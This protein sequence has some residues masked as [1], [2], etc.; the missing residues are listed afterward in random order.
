MSWLAGQP[1]CK[2]VVVTSS[3]SLLSQWRPWLWR[4]W[5]GVVLCAGVA[6][7]ATVFNNHVPLVSAMLVAIVAGVVARN[8]RG[9][10]V[11]ADPGLALTGRTVLRL[12]VVLLGLRLSLRAVAS[13]GW[14]ALGVIALTVLTVFAVTVWVGPRLGVP[15]AAVVLTATGTAICGAAAVA[16]MSAVV[17][18]D[19]V[20]R[21]GGSQAADGAVPAVSGGDADS[22]EESVDE[23]ATTAIASVTLFGTVALLVLPLLVRW[24]GL[25]ATPAGVWVG[26]SVHEVGQVVAAG[27]LISPEV[28]DVAVVAKLGRVVLLA[29]LIAVVGALEGRRQ[30]RLAGLAGGAV[31]A[32]APGD[33]LGGA[34]AVGAD[35]GGARSGGKVRRRGGVPL[36][37]W[38]VVGFVVTVLLRSLTESVVPLAWFEWGSALA[39]F[40]LTMAMFAM[41][42]SVD[43]R[44]LVRGG[45][46]ALGLGAIAAVV[47]VLVSLLGVM[48]LVP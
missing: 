28:L 3:P 2:M 43:L 37:P 25:E 27:G 14:G 31:G 34:G 10:P 35:D 38:F 15:H 23:A 24:L 29:P 30:A 16:G 39:S 46:R 21:A 44:R 20:A 1:R 32:G 17:R 11:A 9:V 19:V 6:V 47:S 18:A 45:G 7:L 40:L 41:G 33:A 26:A 4:V 22:A 42:A 5:P 48:V 8:V 12:G 36:V 13:L